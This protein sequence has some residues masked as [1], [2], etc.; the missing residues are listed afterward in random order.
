MAA[1]GS[2]FA[3][4]NDAAYGIST[5]EVEE[6]LSG[7]PAYLSL[8]EDIRGKVAGLVVGTAMIVVEA[9][10]IGRGGHD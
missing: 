6:L 10:R 3:A 7:T 8:P 2:V 1:R 9:D 5:D 4:F